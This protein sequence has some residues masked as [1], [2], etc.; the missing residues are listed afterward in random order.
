VAF[1][2]FRFPLGLCTE[3]LHLERD[4]ARLPRNFSADVEYDD[5][6][7]L[8]NEDQ[9]PY[10]RACVF[11]EKTRLAGIWFCI[12]FLVQNAITDG[13]VRFSVHDD[14]R[15]LRPWLS[16]RRLYSR[17][18]RGKGH[19]L[20]LP[21]SEKVDI[22]EYKPKRWIAVEDMLAYVLPT[23][24]ELLSDAPHSPSIVF[25]L[26]MA[27]SLI[28]M[29]NNFYLEWRQ[30]KKTIRR[31]LVDVAGVQPRGGLGFGFVGVSNLYRFQGWSQLQTKEA[32]LLAD[33]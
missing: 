9:L 14:R 23:V 2:R 20:H 1:L 8:F 28:Y 11:E 32:I 10:S 6:L 18:F 21:F 3:G 31:Y 33:I 24:E 30:L 27:D 17:H 25:A 13:A 5:W 16:R 26:R 15:K 7:E 22:R 29:H 19:S 4:S 12:N